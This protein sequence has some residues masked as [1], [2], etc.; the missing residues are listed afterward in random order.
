MVMSTEVVSV[1]MGTKSCGCTRKVDSAV[2]QSVCMRMNAIV[3]I[4]GRAC[5][6]VCVHRMCV[7][8]CV[9]TCV[10]ALYVCVYA[11]VT[12]AIVLSR[13]LLPSLTSTHT[14]SLC[15]VDD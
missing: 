3:C 15:E 4:Y 11:S 1:A 10:R 14:S 5:V 2:Y 8:I 12:L 6:Q 9:C 7:C 13:D